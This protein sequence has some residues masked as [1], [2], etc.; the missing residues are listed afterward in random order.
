M[1]A[2][3]VNNSFGPMT[4][5]GSS[6]KKGEDDEVQQLKGK[7]FPEVVHQP[8]GVRVQFAR[9]NTFN[10]DRRNS[11]TIVHSME[12][13]TYEQKYQDFGRYCVKCSEAI[14]STSS[15]AKMVNFDDSDSGH[16][17]EYVCRHRHHECIRPVLVKNANEVIVVTNV[18]A[19]G[20]NTEPDETEK[21]SSS[22]F[23]QIFQ[24]RWKKAF[25]K[26]FRKDQKLKS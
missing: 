7:T 23:L 22:A 10:G 3:N 9:P 12:G 4:A 2:S 25:T 1:V 24:E 15:K 6:S 16:D 5:T 17:E 18:L 13:K 19:G 11:F 20:N 14:A 21:K 8:N 26:S